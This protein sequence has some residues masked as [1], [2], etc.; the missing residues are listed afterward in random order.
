[1][2]KIAALLLALSSLLLSACSA[3]LMS[4]GSY[5]EKATLTA[6]AEQ[7]QEE[8]GPF[9]EVSLSDYVP[10]NTVT[11]KLSW[12]K[13][14]A[15][16]KANETMTPDEARE[17]CVSFFRFCQ[18]FAWVP[19]ASLTF[20][21]NAKGSK[22]T[23]TK[24][25]VYGGL[26]YGGV[27]S[28]TVYRLMEA[29][30]PETG[31]V[32]MKKATPKGETLYFANQCSMG[33]WQGWGRVINSAQYEW[34]AGMTQKNGFLPVGP[35]T[36]DDSISSFSRKTT[37]AIC[38]E[39][40]R[41]V[42]Y[43]SYADLRPADGLVNSEASGGHVIMCS[44]EVEVVYNADGTINGEKSSFP[45]LDQG[46]AFKERKQSD[47]SKYIV[48]GGIDRTVTF[49]G[50]F[51]SG[52]IPFTFAEFLGTD[53]V[54]KAKAEINL[55][56]DS[57]TRADLKKAAI[58]T[59]YSIADVYLD[60]LNESGTTVDQKPIRVTSVVHKRIELAPSVMGSFLTPYENGQYQI[61]I[62]VQ[63]YTGDRLTVYEGKLVK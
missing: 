29:Y 5:E 48:Q 59:N 51:E 41:E 58:Q 50:A 46:Q 4:E 37:E 57:V 17:L 1:M 43:Q 3:G 36:Y 30:N 34:T 56:G 31:V 28:G 15:F 53:P 35:Y 19:D 2:K 25:T 26:P 7:T 13:L 27:S 54:E 32:N 6:T 9:S 44:G 12:D 14:G 33:A 11:D 22:T 39:N 18:T 16:P 38:E 61:R 24:G 62:R 20:E 55:E 63:L 52:Y 40:G 21:R 42:M 45:V 8:G 23:L 10:K 47:G 49:Q 60:I